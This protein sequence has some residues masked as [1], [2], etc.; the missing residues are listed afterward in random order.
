M[1]TAIIFEI[2]VSQIVICGFQ[3][4][5]LVDGIVEVAIVHQ[6]LLSFI[7]A[8]VGRHFFIMECSCD[9]VKGPQV[10]LCHGLLI[11]ALC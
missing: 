11:I 5:V 4:G 2:D 1:Q 8:E 7:N 3:Q 9:A 6:E 10:S